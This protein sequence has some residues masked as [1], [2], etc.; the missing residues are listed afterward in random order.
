MKDLKT[1]IEST[2]DKMQ[3]VNMLVGNMASQKL[4]G[5]TKCRSAL[6][7]GRHGESIIKS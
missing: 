5:Q 4:Q 1:E 3:V 6:G 7:R 2:Q